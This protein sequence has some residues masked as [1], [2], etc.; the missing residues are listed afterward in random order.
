MTRHVLN[1]G[2]NHAGD[3]FVVDDTFVV[4]SDKSMVLDVLSNDGFD[5]Q[6]SVSITK[7]SQPNHGTIKV[8]TDYTIIYTP[9][10]QLPLSTAEETLDNDAEMVDTFTYTT[11]V[12]DEDGTITTDE[13]NV[14]VVIDPEPVVSNECFTDGGKAGD[15]GLKTWCWEDVS[16]PSYSKNTGVNFSNDELSFATECDEESVFKD[17]DQLVFRLNPKMPSTE[18][19]CTRDFN[20]RAEIRTAPWPIKHEPGTEEWF[21]W[22][23]TFNEDYIIDPA[24]EW[25][26]HQVHNGIAGQTPLYELMVARAGLYN[27]SAGEIVVKNNA[28]GPN[29]VLTGIIPRAAQTID[30]VVHVIWGD[31]ANGLLQVWINGNNVYDKQVT[32][33]RPGWEYGGNAKWG[34]YKW[35]WSDSNG[36]EASAQA[37]V[38]DLRTSMGALKIITRRPGDADYGKDSYNQVKP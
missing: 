38:T 8:N 15:T 9:D 16:L 7:T 19:W 20:M 37:G 26:F 25:L 36:V 27:A 5:E 35:T 22:S 17:G 12:V 6:D 28:N 14:T 13:G 3:G 4:P 18:S 31:S 23:Y 21:G 1:E 24:S 11:E 29:H 34:I 33:I 10:I 30:V 32:T 2:Q